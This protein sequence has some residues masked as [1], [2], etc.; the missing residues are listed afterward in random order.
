MHDFG[1]RA[2]A[3]VAING[4]KNLQDIERNFHVNKIQ[5]I[6]LNYSLIA[7]ELQA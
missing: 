6:M 7:A 2:E 5:R 1:S 4:V 3:A